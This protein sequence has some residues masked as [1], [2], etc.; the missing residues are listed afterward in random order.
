MYVIEKGER[1]EQELSSLRPKVSELERSVKVS[2]NEVDCLQE[3]LDGKSRSL[4]EAI[5]ELDLLRSRLSSD[6]DEHQ[7]NQKKI[8][9]LNIQVDVVVGWAVSITTVVFVIYI[10]DWIVTSFSKI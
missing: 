5:K 9:E 2:R 8:D 10:N 4:D 1:L 6:G 3:Q 7:K